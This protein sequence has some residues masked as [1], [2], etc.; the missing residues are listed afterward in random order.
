M[1]RKL[2]ASVA[3]LL[4]IAA[5][6]L[7]PAAAQAGWNVYVANDLS[8][9]A[10][11]YDSATGPL[12]FLATEVAGKG[13]VDV[14]ASPDRTSLYVTNEFA[15]SVSQY[16]FK[17]FGELAPRSP[18]TVAAGVEPNGAAV[19]AIGAKSY[20]YVANEG[21]PSHLYTISEYE[22][23]SSYKLKA[24]G[25]G[26]INDGSFPQP[27][28]V[29]V[30]EDKYVYVAHEGSATVT[31]YEII[32]SGPKEGELAPL[33][34]PSIDTGGDVGG[35][36]V[37]V[38]PNGKY[39]Y[40]PTEA[41]HVW[42]YKINQATG[43]LEHLP[44]PS[45]VESGTPVGIAVKGNEYVYVTNYS[46]NTV[47]QY[48]IEGSGELKELSPPV[49]AGTKPV[50]VA[51]TPNGE[52]VYVANQGSNNVSQYKS[53]PGGELIALK[54]EEVAASGTQPFGLAILEEP[55]A[56]E[57]PEPAFSIEKLQKVE[58]EASFTKS[59]VTG[60]VGETI[61][62]EIVVK[63]TGNVPLTF[64]GFTDAN[65]E[66]LAG[67]P[68]GSEVAPGESTTYTCDH[69]LSKGGSYTNT[70]SDTGTPPE[71][72]GGPVMHTSN[73]VVANVLAPH[74]YSNGTRIAEGKVETVKTSGTLTLHLPASKTEITCKVTDSDRIKN[75]VG[76]GAG[77]DELKT[78]TL[79]GC[80]ATL[81]LCKKGE[82]LEVH[83]GK[84]PW[85]TKLLLGPPIKDEIVG[86]EIKIECKN[87]L[88]G[89]TVIDTYTGSLAPTIGNSVAE[90]GEGSGELE[91]AA[92]AKASVSGLD[93][94][95]GPKG[96][97]VI[98]AK[99]P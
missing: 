90:F 18:A 78:F 27:I 96:D 77:E 42:Q 15:N 53:E 60:D 92:K 44:T 73:T 70:A 37:A 81:A 34:T 5:F 62:Y 69:L 87:K 36:E 47:S 58:D 74:W 65:C 21:G 88:T 66:G 11:E 26:S 71:G 20:L 97:E 8:N 72:K 17:A 82:T 64:S 16:R 43:A 75:P 54:P 50:G 23:E 1:N 25:S 84:L 41:G 40:V 32:Q 93:A 76:G 24:L 14:A 85:A 57:E 29:A 4:V 59:E 61:Y 68:G 89:K 98:T 12:S 94:L 3:P 46:G 45:V 35:Q 49:A 2:F 13:A 6:A 28:W 55:V 83:A 80:K 30:S 9:N 56:S 10:W 38:T 86:M 39:A 52:Y 7:M 33:P 48:K 22:I 95:K 99:T 19:A 67:G 79:T 91:D 63:N 31:E 51:V